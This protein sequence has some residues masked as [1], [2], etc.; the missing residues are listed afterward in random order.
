MFVFVTFLTSIFWFH[1]FY[2]LVLH[3]VFGKHKL[4]TYTTSQIG[5]TGFTTEFLTVANTFNSGKSWT[6]QIYGLLKMKLL[7]LVY[8]VVLSNLCS[9]ELIFRH[10]FANNLYPMCACALETLQNYITFWKTL[11]NELSNIDGSLLSCILMTLWG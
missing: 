8:W 9:R 4:V 10:N 1:Y 11:M 7:S 2:I 5:K 3:Q 6:Y